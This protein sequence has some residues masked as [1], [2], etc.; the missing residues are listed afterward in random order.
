MNLAL[1]RRHFAA[2]GGAELYLQRLIAALAEA[3]HETHLYAEAWKGAPQGVT[4][5]QVPVRATRASRPPRFAE[6]VAG[7][8]RG[9]RHD[10]VLSLERTVSQDVYRAGDGVHAV[11]LE[12]RKRYAPWWRRW[13]IGR[14]AFHRNMLALEK[15]VFDPAVTRHVIANS[16][17]VRQ[18]ILER[19]PFPA[20]RVHLVRNGI[21]TARFQTGER[22][23]ARRSLGLEPGHYALLFAGSGWERKGLRF[24]IALMRRLEKSAP[25]VRLVVAGKGRLLRPPPRNVILAGPMPRVEDAYAAA[26]LFTFLPVYEP[27]SNVVL[28]ALASGLPVITSRF[29]GAAEWVVE[30]ENGHVLADPAD[31]AGLEAAVRHWMARPGARPVSAPFPLELEANVRGTLEVLERAFEEKRAG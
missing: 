29:N 14:G 22:A 31:T 4:L 23:A 19:F 17:M 5:H 21:H 26:D 3:G 2:T 18:E 24:L 10:I 13:L 1:I 27:G 30:G 6:A 7:Q 28:E 15:R 20:E 25:H 16:E 9:A 11:W 12:Q 8:L